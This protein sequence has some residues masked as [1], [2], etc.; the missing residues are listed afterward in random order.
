MKWP[1][2][3]GK[4]IDPWYAGTVV[5]INALMSR[6]TIVYTDGTGTDLTADQVLYAPERDDKWG[7]GNMQGNDIVPVGSVPV[8]FEAQA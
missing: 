3:A 7:E 6:C 8:T 5:A 2:Y 4:A 1:P